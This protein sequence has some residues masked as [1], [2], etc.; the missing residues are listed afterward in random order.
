MF[1]SLLFPGF[2]L[3]LA[4]FTIPTVSFFRGGRLPRTAAISIAFLGCGLILVAST[5]LLGSGGSYSFDFR[6]IKD[7]VFSFSADRLSAFFLVIISL[8]SSVV[9]I[10][11]IEYVE[12]QKSEMRR[13]AIVA[14]MCLF[15]FSM[16]AVVS[17]ADTI[18]FLFFWEMMS[19][20]S[21][22][23][24][25]TEY[26]RE[27]TMKAGLFYLIMTQVGAVFLFAGFIML[28]QA[29]GSF[30]IGYW[31]DLDATHAN[32][33]ISCL[34]IG[35]AMKAGVIPFH[36]WL[37]YAHPASPSNISALMSAVM[38]KVAVYG[39]VR[40]ML[41]P[42]LQM[43]VGWGAIILGAGTLSA[44]LG[45]LYALKEH[46]IKRL[47]AY[48]SI[49]NIGI[50]YIGLGVFTIFRAEN[51]P[52]L[53]ELS[54]FGALFHTLNHS[55]FKSLLFLTAGS[56][57]TATGTRDIEVLG[58][59][60]KRMP[61]T[62]LLFLIGAVS[63]SAL[64]PFNGFVS[65]LMMFQALLQSYTVTEPMLQ[66]YMILCLTVFALTSAFAAACFVK[67]FG[68]TFLAVPRSDNARRAS[69]PHPLMI[70]GP[71]ILAVL[72][73]GLGVFS[74]RIMA[75]LGYIPP[76][77][78]MLLVGVL[79]VGAYAVVYALVFNGASRK[80][81]VCETWG[82]GILSQNYKMEYTASGFSEP[83]MRIFKGVYRT[84][85]QGDMKFYDR[86]GSMFKE[87]H[88]QIHLM[89]F[90]EQSMYMPIA[91]FVDGVATRVARLQNGHLDTYILYIF[92]TILA[93]L[94]AIGWLI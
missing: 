71:A 31:G 63:I 77:P 8:V 80:S 49:E 14:L 20:S 53:A 93:I 40:F 43:G 22:L 58:G 37:P 45:V 17:C 6:L 41:L 36:K 15:I 60:V 7:V 67:A 16:A 2:L 51:L 48:H 46:D 3:L 47:L 62:S 21:L 65:E 57:V 86:Y 52:E 18:S 28:Y 72:C 23:L 85:E 92:I 35:F 39:F 13:N 90:F 69:E 44:V 56:V 29:N 12:H 74:T 59:L 33:L 10:Y 75:L 76:L 66:V 61:Y 34:F 42:R 64:P 19:M 27:E 81:R 70:I 38:L 87:G 82:C 91:N 26:E 30:A 73:V 9:L 4:G 79:L 54:L 1:S 88:A 84:Q 94:V 25:L 5:S 68:V 11:S 83:I 32:I 55:I 78:D 50:I 24:V 89:K